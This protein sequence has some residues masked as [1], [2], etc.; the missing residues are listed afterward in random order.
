[1]NIKF[2]KLNALQ[3]YLICLTWLEARREGAP[4]SE[5]TLD[6][7]T[8]SVLMLTPNTWTELTNVLLQKPHG[9]E[10]KPDYLLALFPKPD[11]HSDA[12]NGQT[13]KLTAADSIDRLL[14]PPPLLHPSPLSREACNWDPKGVL[15]SF[16]ANQAAQ[17]V[18]Q[19]HGY[20]LLAAL[21]MAYAI[22][23]WSP[24]NKASISAA[25]ISELW[26]TSLCIFSLRPSEGLPKTV[27]TS[28]WSILHGRIWEQFCSQQAL[29]QC[30]DQTSS[31]IGL[32]KR[33]KAGEA[34][35]QKDFSDHNN[36]GGA[37][38]SLQ[39]Q[40]ECEGLQKLQEWNCLWAHCYACAKSRRPLQVQVVQ[41]R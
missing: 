39:R 28:V 10:G 24:S 5:D 40:A 9:E 27:N 4:S 6:K 15:E 1:M 12:A 30:I 38:Q 21:P 8:L 20:M 22:Q 41:A 16:R 33:S 11:A 3:T 13:E 14:Y 7:L 26:S 25:I 31:S 35:A 32:Y 18:R 37:T 17:K 29:Q 36:G 23:D 2:T 34:K 19:T